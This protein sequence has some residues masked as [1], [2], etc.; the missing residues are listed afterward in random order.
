MA[1]CGQCNL[2]PD[3]FTVQ[4]CDFGIFM[5]VYGM[6]YYHL[7]RIWFFHVCPLPSSSLHLGPLPST[8]FFYKQ[9]VYKQQAEIVYKSSK[10]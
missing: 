5:K 10:Y 4:T 1:N 8:R 3:P 6:R 7:R 9:H 2:Q